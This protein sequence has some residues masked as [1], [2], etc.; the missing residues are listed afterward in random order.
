MQLKWK[1]Q[2]FRVHLKKVLWQDMGW[3]HHGALILCSGR[4]RSRRKRRLKPSQSMGWEGRQLSFLRWNFANISTKLEHYII[5]FLKNS[6]QTQNKETTVATHMLFW[7]SLTDAQDTYRWTKYWPTPI[8]K[9][10]RVISPKNHAAELRTV[11]SQF[12]I[13]PTRCAPAA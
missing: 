8:W 4:D 2:S 1:V 13:S 5:C 7:A 11:G 12:K 10:M 6:F 3:E 9:N